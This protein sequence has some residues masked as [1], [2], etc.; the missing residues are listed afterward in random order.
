MTIPLPRV[1]SSHGL[2]LPFSGSSG[3]VVLQAPLHAPGRGLDWVLS[4]FFYDAV[5]DAVCRRSLPPIGSLSP[6]HQLTSRCGL[7]C[8]GFTLAAL[9]LLFPT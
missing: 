4:P 8:L 6:A 9:L 2:R 1:S 5:L 3:Q 7:L